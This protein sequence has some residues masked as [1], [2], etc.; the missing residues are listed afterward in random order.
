[1]GTRADDLRHEIADVR[2]DLG[3]TLEAIG[4][5]VAPDKVMERAKADLSEKVDDVKEKVS[6]KRLAQKG[7]DSV[8]RGVRTVVGSDDDGD[9]GATRVPALSGATAG[10]GR[11]AAGTAAG[12]SRQAAG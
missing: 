10:R 2:G 5:K 11:Q 12:R 8:R 3:E 9:A 4:D 7:A 6:P 1:M